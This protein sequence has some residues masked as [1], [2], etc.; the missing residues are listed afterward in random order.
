[1]AHAFAQELTDRSLTLIGGG[2]ASLPVALH[3]GPV[4]RVLSIGYADSRRAEINEV[5]DHELERVGGFVR[6][7]RL[8]ERSDDDDL[9]RVRE[10]AREADVVVFASYARALPWK[11]DLGL[12]ADVAELAGELARQGAIV[13][14]FGDPYVLGQLPGDGAYLLA[15]TDSDAAQRAAARA[16]AGRIP[17]TGRLPVTVPPL[18]TIGDGISLPMLADQVPAAAELAEPVSSSERP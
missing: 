3:R 18:Y 15:W 7:I 14:G 8:W 12:P 10:A 1:D 13:V 4:L 11:G 9:E 16:I 6:A 17:V 5:F 2:A